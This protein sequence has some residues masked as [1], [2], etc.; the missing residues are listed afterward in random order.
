MQ[1]KIEMVPVCVALFHLFSFNVH[2]SHVENFSW[3]KKWPKG[4]Y[5]EIS[6]G[7]A[8]KKQTKQNKKKQKQKNPCKF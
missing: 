6:T 7:A 2:S 4:Y 8:S 3:K 5:L 1:I